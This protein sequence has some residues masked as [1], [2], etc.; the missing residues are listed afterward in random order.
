[1]NAPAPSAPTQATGLAKAINL[2][3]PALM[4][5]MTISAFLRSPAPPWHEW[6]WLAAYW[7]Q[8]AIRAP[9]AHA[10]AANIVTLANR[11]LSEKIGLAAMF[12]TMG[13]LPLIHVGTGAFGFAAYELPAWAAMIGAALQVPFLWLFWRSHAD[14][15]RNWSATLELR[16]GHQLVTRGIYARI[17]HPMYAAIWC[18]VLGQPLLV[19]NWLAGLPIVAAFTFM[20]AVRMPREEALMRAEFEAEYDAYCARTGRILPRLGWS[21]ASP[22][23]PDDPPLPDKH[24][25]RARDPRSDG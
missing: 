4:L 9:H 25:A 12:L 13:L 20:W 8:G 14:L 7:V 17:R 5:A 21:E 19:Q 18:A 3:F 24:A 16:E 1:M 10:N 15:G 6:V 23:M 2:I 22:Y 11:D